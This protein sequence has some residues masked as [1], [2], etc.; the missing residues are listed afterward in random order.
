MINSFVF[1]NQGSN[2]YL[3]YFISGQ[4][5]DYF[6]YEDDTDRDFEAMYGDYQEIPF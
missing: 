6:L 1:T 4:W 5:I 2:W 3:C